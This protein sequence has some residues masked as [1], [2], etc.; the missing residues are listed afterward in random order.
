MLNGA[1]LGGVDGAQTVDGAA[2]GVHHPAQ[3]ALAHR[4][5]G[6][7]TGAADGAALPQ[8]G[9][10]PQ[11]DAAHRVPGQ[12]HN[13]PPDPGVKLHQFAVHRPVQAVDGGDAVAY[14]QDSALLGAAGLVVISFDLLP[15]EGDDLFRSCFHSALPS[16]SVRARASKPPRTLLS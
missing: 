15:Q 3:H 2:Q 6:G 14:L 5:V 12:I 11:Q 7:L 16:P 4:D 1:P 13:H 10:G 8:A 9:L